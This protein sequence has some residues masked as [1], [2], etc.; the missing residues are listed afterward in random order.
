MAN[1]Q[2]TSDLLIIG[3]GVLGA[4]H[5]Y[6]A[7]R[8]GLSVTLLE[9]HP[10]PRGA[11]VR[12]FGQVVPSGLDRHWQPLG[13]ESLAIYKDLQARFD[14]SVRQHGSLYIASDDDELQLIEEL[15][16]INAATGYRSELWTAKQCRERYPNL[17]SDYCRG[18][19]FFS[20]EIS[21]NP[22]VMIHRVHAFLSEQDRFRGCFQN[23]VRELTTDSSDRVRAVTHDG[24]LFTAENAILCC[25]TEL[26]GLF[27]GVFR[28]SGMEVV[29][30]Q[31]LRLKPQGNVSIPGNILTGLSIRRYESFAECP[32]WKAV[33]S[34]EPVDAFWKRW[35]VH[36]LFK[37]EVDG[38]IILGDSHEY[39]PVARMND[40]SFDIRQEVNDYFIRE[41][42]K[43]FALSRWDV[44]QSW[45]GLYCQSNAT[46]GIY[47]KT[48]DDRIH[49]VTGIGGK[50]MTSSPGYALHHL[51]E[52]YDD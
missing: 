42:S 40:L 29:K 27:P 5:A 43:I 35:G 22:R 25:G 13:R 17:R 15:R 4:F 20:E 19:L 45:Y 24:S 7:L 26:Q 51:G 10:A 44:E 23:G 9:R 34:R 8:R 21:V 50:G 46:S 30:L 6:H 18:G 11:T 28:S 12:N 3:G 31:M 39:A 14:I 52:I 36:V 47:T 48:I 1:S 41:G 38:G 49:I 33:K 16:T 32:S 2:N 37:Q